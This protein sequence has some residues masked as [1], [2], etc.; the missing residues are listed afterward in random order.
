MNQIVAVTGTKGKTSLIR[1]LE[2]ALLGL[3]ENVLRVDTS[4]AYYNQ[5]LC[6]SDDESRQIWGYAVT[7]A[8]GRFL[9][10]KGKEPGIA[11]L[12]CTLFSAH[13]GLAY[14]AHDIGVFTNVYEDHI[15]SFASIRTKQDIANM[16]GFVFS[17]TKA[18]GTVIYNADDEH[19]TT[20]LS[21]VPS[22][23]KR[24]AVSMQGHSAPEADYNIHYLD[25]DV[26]IT[27]A[28]SKILQRIDATKM[29]WF[30]AGY[31][32][33]A[34]LTLFAFAVLFVVCDEETFTKAVGLLKKYE[35]DPEG[36]RMV[37]VRLRNGALAILDYAH[38]KVSLHEVSQYAK[39]LVAPNGKVIGVLRLAPSRT[40]E[41]INDTATHIYNDYDEFVIYDKVD[42][43][44]RQ[45]KKI[46]GYK[47]KQEETGKVAELFEKALLAAGAS[48]VHKVIRE[49]KALEE[50]V[51][52][53][54]KG[55][56]IVYIVGDDSA[57]SR[58]FIQQFQSKEEV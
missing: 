21:K 24:I 51:N 54:C 12:E 53:S 4:G 13:T 42:G 2:F 27:D 18:D 44:L 56:V 16:K 7:N 15:G 50:A 23:A 48:R 39:T 38:E 14:K 19:V 47:S 8:P 1:L 55:D 49:D 45:P 33:I 11:L 31:L 10:I 20:Q 25:G 28:T 3:H 58:Q 41:L 36:G 40:E 17:R 30:E 34:S 9:A 57:R 35:F 5:K 43:H 22:G 52:L 26:I 32:P 29:P 46:K 37:K 6:F